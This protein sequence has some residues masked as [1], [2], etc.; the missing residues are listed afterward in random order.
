M[1]L[2]LIAP[3]LLVIAAIAGAFVLTETDSIADAWLVLATGLALTAV[4]A[5]LAVTSQRRRRATREVERYFTLSPEMVI[6]AGFDGYWKRVNPAV[7][8]V[9]GYTEREAL[10]RPFMEF[11]HPDDRERTEQEAGRVVGGAT[12]LSFENRMLCKDGSYKWIE[13]A[14]TPVPE[15]GVMYGVG[16]DVTERRRSES[17]QT[18]LRRLGTLVAEGVPDAVFFDGV[19]REVSRVVGV[20]MVTIDRYEQE[21][22][23]STVVASLDDPGFPVGSSWPIDGPSLAATVFETG[24]PAR[25]DDYAGLDSSSA[26]AARKWSVSSTV[27]VP[28]VVDGA[29]WGVICVGTSSPEPLPRDIEG[30]LA[31]FT[32]LA[33]TA[34]A[35]ADSRTEVGRLATQQAALRRVATLVA[36]GAAPADV[37]TAVAW[38]VAQLFD[39]AAV[40]LSRYEDDAVG[41]GC[42]PAGQRLPRRQPLAVRRRQPL[43]T[44][45]CDRANGPDRRLHRHRRVGRCPYAVA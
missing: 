21:G 40:T 27:G 17:E 37:F 39:F 7:E 14:A 38:E 5:A 13:W 4:T 45:A 44:S 6:L 18:A 22:S 34:I 9:L 11:V 2:R 8:A 24:R 28:I 20:D 26:A 16:R 30:R 43:G 12:A 15:D 19:A 33:A 29:I 42:G 41:G 25:V 36:E 35:N 10:A 32:E 1:R 23:A 31:A 3:V